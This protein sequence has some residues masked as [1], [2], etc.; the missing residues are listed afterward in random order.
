MDQPSAFD[1]EKTEARSEL[2]RRIMRRQ[3]AL[4]IRVAAVFILLLLLLP[5]ANLYLPDLMGSNAGGFT[6]TWLLLGVLFYPITWVLSAYFVRESE[7]VESS[8]AQSE[9]GEAK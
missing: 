5:L 9:A 4:S 1:G 6:F 8:I 2:L 3:A 7:K